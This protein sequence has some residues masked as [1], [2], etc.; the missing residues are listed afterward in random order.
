M[1]VMSGGVTQPQLTDSDWQALY[2]VEFV[3][4]IVHQI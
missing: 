2:V 4:D 3:V 1:P